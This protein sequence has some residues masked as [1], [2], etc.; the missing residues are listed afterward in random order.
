MAE[1]LTKETRV[2]WWIHV[3]GYGGFAYFATPSEAERRMRDKA[4][5]EGGRG[6]LRLATA[7]EIKDERDHLAWKRDNLY[8]LEPHEQEALQ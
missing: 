4:R 3:A 2:W 7:N 1:P 5:W 6:S 8:P